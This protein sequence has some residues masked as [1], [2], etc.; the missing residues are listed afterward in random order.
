MSNHDYYERLKNNIMT[1]KRLGGQIGLH[2]KRVNKILNQIDV[3]PDQPTDNEWS[4][5]NSI[6]KGKYLVVCFIMNSNKRQYSTLIRDIK[7]D[8]T[9]EV[10]THTQK[11]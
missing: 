10:Q 1:A 11:H 3:I 2:N 9:Q 6:A 4:M 8:H 5:A 7:N